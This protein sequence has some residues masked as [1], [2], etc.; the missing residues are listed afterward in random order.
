[1]VSVA[2]LVTPLY[3]AEMTAEVWEDTDTVEMV[4]VAD[5]APR[6]R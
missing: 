2:D 4:N 3:E 1:M 5:A 6:P